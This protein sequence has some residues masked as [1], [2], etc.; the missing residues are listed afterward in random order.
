MIGCFRHDFLS[1]NPGISWLVWTCGSDFCGWS[2]LAIIPD[3]SLAGCSPADRRC[4]RLSPLTP[5][6][7]FNAKGPCRGGPRIGS[8]ESSDTNAASRD[9][10]KICG[11][12]G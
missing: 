7:G 5:K 10:S 4:E 1:S 8:K 9:Q 3:L 11:P 2:E 6:A 12:E